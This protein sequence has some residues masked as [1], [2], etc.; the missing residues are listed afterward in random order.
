MMPHIMKKTCDE[1][2]DALLNTEGS[3]M[4]CEQDLTMCYWV[5]DS[6]FKD[7]PKFEQIPAKYA[8]GGEKYEEH[9]GEQG[10]AL[11]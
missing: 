8:I 2:K 3:L 10:Q 1:Y 7:D 6:S 9:C 11:L 4:Y 5:S